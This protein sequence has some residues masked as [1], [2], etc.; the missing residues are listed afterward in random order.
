MR[1]LIFSNFELDLSPYKL[2]VVREN[3]WFSDAFFTKYSFPFE[4]EW[5]DEID[6]VF[7]FL[8]RYNST[9]H[10]TRLECKYY[11]NNTISDAIFEI[12]QCQEVISGVI[13]FGYEELPNFEKK[14]SELPLDKFELP[15]GVN[16]YDHAESV[17]TQSWPNVNYNFPQIHTDKIDVDNDDIFF[18]FERI[19]N[20]YK[21]GAF[22]INEVI[23]EGSEEV[24]YNRN[25][26]QPLPHFLHIT[27]KIFEDIGLTLQGEILTDTRFLNKYIFADVDYATTVT[28]ESISIIQM[29]EDSIEQG[30]VATTVF[31]NY[32]DFKKYSYTAPI[33][34]PGRYRIVGKVHR[35]LIPNF[36]T[37]IR[38]KYRDQIIWQSSGSDGFYKV[39]KN[40][41]V[42]FDTLVDLLPNEITVES[43][44]AST[45]EKIIFELDINPVRLHDTE[46]NPIPSII[47]KNEIDLTKSVPDMNCGD[48]LK[49]IKNIYNYDLSVQG[50][51]ATMN[52]VNTQINYQDAIDL[53][54]TEVK[55][56]VRK[57][58]KGN[59]F[60]LKYQ[61]I[62]SK[63]YTFLPVFHDSNGVVNSSFV[64]T[65]KTIEIEINALPLPLLQRNGVQTAHACENNNSKP[66]FVVYSGVNSSGLNLS[67][68]P[69]D[70]LMPAIHQEYHLNWMNFRINTQEFFWT[71]R[72]F[73]EEFIQLKPNSKVFAYGRFHV[74]KN[75][76]DTEVAPDEF[77]IEIETALLE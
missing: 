4:I 73:S 76:N 18:A 46:G 56:P 77:E 16:I 71:L 72:M 64:K 32:R 23:T 30:T 35:Y 28:Q 33:A 37:Y 6:E 62:D 54:H 44:Q 9:T 66:Y 42:V 17:M 63:D 45:E 12:E 25:I 53:R 5:S 68:D 10:Q 51:I 47:N 20:N 69:A 3:H 59:S 31:G 40:V 74:I 1:K 75:I 2:S 39:V 61:D 49:M 19:I 26:M 43:F 11:H 24:T 48:W 7:G 21:D 29:S 13:Y 27:K 57:F 52:R 50:S 22:L 14:L 58:M 41:N 8:S 15:E 67:N 38:I 70:F 55:R 60:I 65:D 34:N 36:T